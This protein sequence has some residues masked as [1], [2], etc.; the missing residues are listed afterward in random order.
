MTSAMRM[1]ADCGC[2]VG[3]NERGWLL[4]RVTSI[5]TPMPAPKEKFAPGFGLKNRLTSS[6]V[7]QSLLAVTSSGAKSSD[8]SGRISLGQR[9]LLRRVLVERDSARELIPKRCLKEFRRG[10]LASESRFE[11]VCSGERAAD[12]LGEKC[13][14]VAGNRFDRCAGR[15]PEFD[16]DGAFCGFDL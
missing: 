3:G 1:P 2:F 16:G 7:C 11:A 4:R 15:L 6:I 13:S 12:F 10:C 14:R 9:L 8:A 5:M